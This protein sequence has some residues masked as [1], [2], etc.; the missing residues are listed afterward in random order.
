MPVRTGTTG[1]TRMH[2][3]RPM[4][5]FM[6]W[7]QAA[8]RKLADQYPH[9][10]NAELSKT[11]GRLWRMLSEDEK[12]PFMDEAERLRLQHKKDHPDYKYQPRRKK[13]SK[14]G[15]SGETGNEPEITAS[16][17][18]RVIKG[19]SNVS[20]VSKSRTESNSDYSE[21][22]HSPELSP[23]EYSP[24]SSC[25]SSVPFSP[26]DPP[27]ARMC[28]PQGAGIEL[29]TEILE[30]IVKSDVSQVTYNKQHQTLNENNFDNTSL[31]LYLSTTT[32]AFTYDNR[33]VNVPINNSSM[34]TSVQPNT[35][36]CLTYNQAQSH[37]LR[38]TRLPKTT[39]RYNPYNIDTKNYYQ[40]MNLNTD[41]CSTMN[42]TGSAY[43][44]PFVNSYQDTTAA[45][46]ISPP[47]QPNVS[48]SEEFTIGNRSNCLYGNTVTGQQFSMDQ[49]SAQQHMLGITTTVQNFTPFTCVQQQAAMNVPPVHTQQ[50]QMINSYHGQSMQW[51]QSQ[52]YSTQDNVYPPSYDYGQNQ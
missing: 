36:S 50:S 43:N 34:S 32:D 19:G 49:Q 16:D 33:H 28:S 29:P 22:A 52:F 46:Q 2:V 37:V 1:R 39:G 13:Q 25:S 8:R 11:L 38:E 18:L 27:K 17:L 35:G 5:A 7:A 9:L 51:Q 41:S 24:K 40:N 44:L 10:H 42:S 30:T 14:E 31:D 6:V 45:V 48:E 47:I 23:Y 3:K 21:G 12:K 4:N 20:E 26:Q 15:S